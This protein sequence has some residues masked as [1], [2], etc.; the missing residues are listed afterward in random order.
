MSHVACRFKESLNRLSN[1]R[2]VHVTLLSLRNVHVECQYLLD[3]M[4]H[5]TKA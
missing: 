5:V 2:N 3:V 1:L 4:S